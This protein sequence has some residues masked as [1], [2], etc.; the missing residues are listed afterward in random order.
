MLFCSVCSGGISE[1]M[2]FYNISLGF[3]K[4][5]LFRREN[6]NK[7]SS[8][9]IFIDLIAEPETNDEMKSFFWKIEKVVLKCF[10]INLSVLDQK[11]FFKCQT[12]KTC[13]IFIQIVQALTHVYDNPTVGYPFLLPYG[14]YVTCYCY[15]MIWLLTCLLQFSA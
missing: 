9:W 12:S 13:N 2:Q 6:F 8:F 1:E 3:M 7:M 11:T 14:S 5:V 4:V 10:W 15:L